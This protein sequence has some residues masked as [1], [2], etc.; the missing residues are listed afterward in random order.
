MSKDPKQIYRLYSFPEADKIVKDY[1]LNK[2]EK[3]GSVKLIIPD[4]FVDAFRQ[5]D[6]TQL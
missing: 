2:D 3:N 6:T 5:K 4:D 1:L